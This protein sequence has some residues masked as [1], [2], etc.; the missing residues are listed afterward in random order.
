M[1]TETPFPITVDSDGAT[2]YDVATIVGAGSDM[3][4]VDVAAATTWSL[5]GANA[6]T[7]AVAG[8]SSITFSGIGYLVG[9]DG[10][11]TFGFAGGAV[12]GT[13]NGG[14]GVN[15]LD[16]SSRTTNVTVNLIT[17]SGTGTG[18]I[19][20]IQNAIGGDGNDTLTGDASNNV[21]TGG[22]GKDIINGGGGSD[23]VVETRDANF[24]LA[25]TRLTI[26]AEGE[27]ILSSIE[28]AHLTGGSGNN[29]LTASSFTGA[30]V[31][32]GGAGNDTL[33]GGPAPTC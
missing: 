16:Y 25:N 27:E 4:V 21:L 19:S 32:D 17:G 12:T 33:R 29:S 23:T 22:L 28:A 15:T 13:I 14:A 2:H 6:G 30:V 24:T 10:D 7:I 9:G 18:G 20:S 31:L 5:T 3:V 8:Y 26:G 1:R 11:D